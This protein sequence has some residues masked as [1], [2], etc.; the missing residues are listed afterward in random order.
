MK[1]LIFIIFMFLSVL[2]NAQDIIQQKNG[3]KI[4]AKVIEITPEL[5][6]YKK[7][8]VIAFIYN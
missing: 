3:E 4:S 8:I 1:N 5:V 6:K 7:F 2:L